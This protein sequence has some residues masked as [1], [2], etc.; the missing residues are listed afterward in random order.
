MSVAQGLLGLAIACAFWHAAVGILICI[1]LSKR[2]VKVNYLFIKALIPWYAHRYKSITLQETGRVGP[3]FYHWIV[4]INA[5]L[6]AGIAG[7]V[8]LRM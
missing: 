8:A 7:I 6:V 1:D 4:S 5:T 3:L 2:G